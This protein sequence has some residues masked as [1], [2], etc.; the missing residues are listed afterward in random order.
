MKANMGTA[1]RTIRILIA[2]AIGVLYYLHV[3]SGTLAIVL[4]VIAVVFVLT[5]F[6]AFCPGYLPFGISTRGGKPSS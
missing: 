3:I 5:S 1:D 4:G 2:V 6:V